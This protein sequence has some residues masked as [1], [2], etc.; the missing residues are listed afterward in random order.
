MQN[1]CP[2]PDIFHYSSLTR[3]V[4]SP[5]TPRDQKAFSSGHFATRLPGTMPEAKLLGW[6]VSVFACGTCF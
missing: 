5:A 3:F 6:Y 2:R 1:D 4:E